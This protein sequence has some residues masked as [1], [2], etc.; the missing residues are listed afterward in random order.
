MDEAE[1]EEYDVN[2]EV[3]RAGDD[4]EDEDD[5]RCEVVRVV[6]CASVVTE[7]DVD[8][9]FAEDKPVGIDLVVRTVD[10]DADADPITAIDAE[11]LSPSVLLLT[12]VVTVATIVVTV[13]VPTGEEGSAIIGTLSSESSSLEPRRLSSGILR[14]VATGSGIVSSASMGM[15]T[16]MKSIGSS[17]DDDCCGD[18]FGK[19]LTISLDF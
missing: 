3:A 11:A 13:T 19:R 9:L 16:R 14:Y 2:E 4:D 12:L 8:R 18:G 17:D 15:E 6:N 1:S 10:T 7:L 5:K